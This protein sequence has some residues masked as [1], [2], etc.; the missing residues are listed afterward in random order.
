MPRRWLESLDYSFK[1]ARN[2]PVLQLGQWI[3]VYRGQ[4]KLS[5]PLHP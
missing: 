2:Q 5:G 4:Q 1:P 3:G